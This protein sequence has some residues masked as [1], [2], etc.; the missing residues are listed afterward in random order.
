[1]RLCTIC[2]HP[3]RTEIDR[4]LVD[5]ETFRNVAKRFGIGASAVYRHKQHL[6]QHLAKAAKAT[7]QQN[8]TALVGRV[9]EKE[10]IEFRS[11]RDL[12]ARL[13]DLEAETRSIL[14]EAR[15]ATTQVPCSKC[16][17]TVEIRTGSNDTA[18]KAI[19]RLENQLRLAGDI[20]GLLQKKLSV[21]VRTIRSYGDLTAEELEFL[22]AEVEQAHATRALNEGGAN[23]SA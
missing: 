23:G 11:A 5:N 12:L 20:L 3:Q 15:S 18:L 4:A 2:K 1:M 7:E 21:E 13:G 17:A 22:I 9:Q 16:G 8:A 6:P 10:V 14:A 19:N